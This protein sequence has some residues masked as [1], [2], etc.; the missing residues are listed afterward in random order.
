MYDYRDSAWLNTKLLEYKYDVGRVAAL[1]SVS[2]VTIYNW[3]RKHGIKSPDFNEGG[4]CRN[5]G[6]P[7]EFG[8]YATVQSKGFCSPRCRR[9]WKRVQSRK[10]KRTCISCGRE[11]YSTHE[12]GKFHSYKCRSAWLE[13]QRY[14][15][16]PES[17]G[18]RVCSIC[19]EEKLLSE[20]EGGRQGKYLKN[21]QECRSELW[22]EK[23]RRKRK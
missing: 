3:M 17:R 6:K 11:Y 7:I 12:H 18:M 13:K 23:L 14:E 1:C 10:Y 2:V 22:K 5:C 15:E 21:C 19:G 8:K 4:V 9:R 20:F 16:S